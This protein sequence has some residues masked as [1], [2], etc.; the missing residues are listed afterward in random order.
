MNR[1]IFYSLVIG[2]FLLFSA[3]PH[4]SGE[5]SIL[6]T[7]SLPE[8]AASLFTLSPNSAESKKI[9]EPVI[10]N[11]NLLFIDHLSAIEKIFNPPEK[12]KMFEE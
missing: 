5:N 7:Q 1:R 8:T 12:T 11:Q 6:N 9:T 2:L 4:V 3:T 10:P